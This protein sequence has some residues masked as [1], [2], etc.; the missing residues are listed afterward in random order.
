MLERHDLDCLLEDECIHQET[1]ETSEQEDADK[2]SDREYQAGF[3]S[4][5][6]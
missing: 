4:P 2:L 6:N 5:P 3:W 1:P